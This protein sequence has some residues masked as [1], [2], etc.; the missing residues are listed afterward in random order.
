MFVMTGTNLVRVVC[1]SIRD[2]REKE[3]LIEKREKRD[4]SFPHETEQIL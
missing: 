2:G 4:I 1:V 3:R